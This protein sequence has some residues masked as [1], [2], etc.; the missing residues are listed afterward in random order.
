MNSFKHLKLTLKDYLKLIL[1]IFIFTLVGSGLSWVIAPI[2]A[3]FYGFFSQ[4]F[5]SSNVFVLVM[6][7]DVIFTVAA[8][9]FACFLC[10]KKAKK[11]AAL[12]TILT[13][14]LLWILVI[15]GGGGLYEVVFNKDFPV[16]YG[17]MS[18][19]EAP[20]ACFIAFRF[21]RNARIAKN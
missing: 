18:L 12:A 17:L 4:I 20:I 10:L 19:I 16:W 2:L 5:F 21:A 3:I 14:F 11:N 15:I 1:T 9:S 7:A 13:A 6:I 8:E